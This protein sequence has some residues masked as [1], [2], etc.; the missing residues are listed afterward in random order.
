MESNKMYECQIPGCGRLVSIRSTIK[1][2]KFK[3]VK[4]CSICKSKHC[5]KKVI[6]KPKKSI[7]KS[8][9]KAVNKRKVERE[10]LPEFF[11]S[12]IELLVGK[13]FCE[14]CGCR[15]NYNLHPVNNIAH[16]LPKRKYKSVMKNPNNVLFLC[17]TKDHPTSK[18]KSCHFQYDSSISQRPFMPV[19]NIAK[20]KFDEMRDDI[21]E[22]GIEYLIFSQE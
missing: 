3:G 9:P 22:S 21:L 7:I 17:D 4:C 8:S 11:K 1:E 19:F 5:T 14:N 16:I 10:G 15:I 12:Q 2:G 18:P 6:S 20:N 13:P